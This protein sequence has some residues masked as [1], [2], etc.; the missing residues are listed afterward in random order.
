VT[1]RALGVGLGVVEV[2]TGLGGGVLLVVV[3]V[4]VA[5]DDV[6]IGFDATGPIPQPA[7][8]ASTPKTATTGMYRV[9]PDY[10]AP[11]WL[12]VTHRRTANS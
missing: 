5:A 3:V 7:S 1:V 8:I 6:A 4:V 10:L 2:T 12:R 11:W 9:T